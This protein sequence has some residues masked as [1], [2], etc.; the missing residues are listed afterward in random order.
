MHK[1]TFIVFCGGEGSGK[2]TQAKLLADALERR[3]KDFLLTK[4][5]GGT[6]P[7]ED[8]RAILLNKEYKG[9][10]D[11]RAELL[12]FESARA[13]HAAK[14]VIPALEAGTLVISDRFNEATWAYQCRGRGI[15][16]P[17]EFAM[18]DGFARGGLEPDLYLFVDIEPE[19]GLA[20]KRTQQ[21]VNRFEEEEL[22]FHQKVREGHR[23]FLKMFASDRHHIFD[24]VQPPDALHREIISALEQKQLF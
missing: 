22:A 16:T 3:G 12:L 5:P 9:M 14:K 11:F 24:G 4:E 2:T 7:G 6:P 21:E 15:C 10:L 23:E 13:Q 8:I 17:E 18:I 19:V 1:G 20:R